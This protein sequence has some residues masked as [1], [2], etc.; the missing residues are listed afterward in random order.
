MPRLYS[1]LIALTVFV[2]DRATKLVI[3]SYVSFY[4]TIPVIPGV[5]N[6]VHSKN[7]GAAF[8]ILADSDSEWRGFFLIGVSVVVLAF[9]L[10]LLWQPSRAGMQHNR[11]LA[12]G[13]SLVLGGA[14]GNVY[15]RVMY[16][17]VTDFLQVFLGSYEWPSFNVADSAIVVGAG[18]L[19]IDM[20]RSSGRESATNA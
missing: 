6:I 9:L 7:R 11:M 3:E 14:L 20:W 5:F 16:G 18:L 1:Y 8:G 17:S 15:D 19:L 10:V 13:L 12:W 2:L 4:D